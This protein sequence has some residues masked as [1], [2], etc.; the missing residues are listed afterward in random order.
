LSH[1]DLG[2]RNVEKLYK[3]VMNSD[4]QKLFIAEWVKEYEGLLRLANESAIHSVDL[5]GLIESLPRILIS[6]HLNAIGYI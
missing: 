4:C 1:E 3:R 5:K 6:L 2:E